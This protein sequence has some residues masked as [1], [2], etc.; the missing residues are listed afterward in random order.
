MKIIIKIWML[1]LFFVFSSGK[2]SIAQKESL[3]FEHIGIEEGLS[4]DNIT[5]IFQDSRGYI[6]IGT[7][8]GLNKYDGY[9]FTKYR[10]DPFDPNSISQNWIYTIFEDSYG[11][12]W[13]SSFEGMC[14][15]DRATEKFT[16]YKPS[17]KARFADPNIGVINEDSD[18]MIWVG[19]YS[20]GLCRFNPQ[21]ENFLPDSID[22]DYPRSPDNKATWPGDAI[23]CI[24]KD[25]AGTLWVGNTTGLHNIKLTTIKAGQ[26]SEYS[27]IH[28][29]PDPFNPDSLSG[30]VTSV[31]EDKAGIIW[32]ATN[33]GLNSLDKK[34]G[35]FK[36]YQNDP[37]NIQS[38]SSNNSFSWGGRGI[39]E[40][41]QGN[42]WIC[43]SKGLNKLN[44]NR[45]V[46]TRYFHNPNDPH[47]VSRDDIKSLE[48]DKAGILWVGSENKLNKAN[49]N[50]KGF[51]LRSNDPTDINSLSSNKVTSILEDSSGIFWIGTLSGGL[52]RWDKRTNQ[53]THFR[54]GPANPKSLRHDAVLAILKDRHGHLWVGNGDI[55]S[56]F[57]KQTGEFT[58][59]KSNEP[60]YEEGK[61]LI[62]CIA[63][64]R[65]GLLW[66]GAGEGIKIFDTK[67]RKFVKYYRHSKADSTG[68]S[69]YNAVA[70]FEDSENNIWVG[71]GSI[72]TD[73]LNKQTGVI[74]H[75]KHDPKDTASISSNNVYSFYEDTKGNLWLGTWGGGLCR[76]DY[77]TG[78][79]T[80]FTDKHGLADN[81]VYSILEDNKKYL[82][83]GTQNGLSRFD[84]VKKT[85]TNY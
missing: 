46:F 33:N 66:L 13:V 74:T 82:W 79:F 31:F 47:S 11:V 29:R 6:W 52:N 34:T 53:F 76:F 51:G 64:D 35:R 48:I 65:E 70:I 71:Y 26:P 57:N 2:N 1:I 68:I 42:L 10:F 45:T 22:L 50:D 3:R 18:G 44:K 39:K 58:H 75:Y 72:A 12:I 80:T 54:H 19:S 85:F 43:T 69:D 28:Y 21:T 20:T 14:K 55:L 8:D 38:I 27:I 4:N 32:V 63:D 78:K 15:F 30:I 7:A 41:Q 73:R 5:A 40:D 37:K 24:Y 77:K 17:P 59:Y 60:N 61:Q 9:T 16:R 23:N 67:T 25:M 36:S 49:L 62:K 56:L 81:I 83:L 84:P